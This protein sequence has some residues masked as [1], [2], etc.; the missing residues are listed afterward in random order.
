MIYFQQV[1][2][3][4]KKYSNL[5]TNLSMIYFQQ[6]EEDYKKYSNLITNLPMIYFE[7][8]IKNILT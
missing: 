1:E 7:G 3:D 4:Y 6:V 5:I 8:S 2:E